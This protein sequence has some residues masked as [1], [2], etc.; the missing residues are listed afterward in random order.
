VENR[1]EYEKT[2]KSVENREKNIKNFQNA[3]LSIT[4]SHFY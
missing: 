4:L 3:E 1:G 2:W